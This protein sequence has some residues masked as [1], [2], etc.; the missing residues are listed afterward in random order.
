LKLQIGTERV[1]IVPDL[2][3]PFQHP[4]AF[5]FLKAVARKE[6]PTIVINIGDSIDAN[7][8]S[9]YITSPDGY[10]A[11]M[12]HKLTLE[13][14][15]EFYNIFPAGIEVESNH[16]ARI[17]KRAYDAGIPKE[18]LKSYA[19]LVEAPASWSFVESAEIDNIIY[20]H[21]HNFDGMYAART[22]AIVNRKSTVMGHHHGFG[23]IHYI[24]NRQDMIFGMNVGCLIDEKAYAF[25]Y[26]KSHKFKPTLM[27]GVVDRGVPKI[28]PMVVDNTGRWI[29]EL[30]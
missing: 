21:G 10:S 28:Y 12:E 6:G 29:Q 27:C 13:T 23:G 18:Y 5:A 16:N 25:E 26:A 11:G 2:Q 15:K 7:A 17:Y 8:I 24:A 3:I 14:L 9:R 22:A 19:E 1:L 4:D 30:F 20:E